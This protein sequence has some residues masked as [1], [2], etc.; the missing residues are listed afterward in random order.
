MLQ[1][2]S[3]VV[4]VAAM[5]NEDVISGSGDNEEVGGQRIDD[6]TGRIDDATG[7]IDGE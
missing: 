3:V 1:F 4:A 7:R 5:I 2:N 6:A